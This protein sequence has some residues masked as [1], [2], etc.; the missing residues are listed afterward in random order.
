MAATER[1]GGLDDADA[2]ALRSLGIDLDQVVRHAEQAS[3][4]GALAQQ[5]GAPA[6]RQLMGVRV[7]AEIAPRGLRNRL[8]SGPFNLGFL[9]VTAIQDGARAARLL[10]EL[11]VQPDKVRSRLQAVSATGALPDRRQVG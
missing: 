3:R 2:E 7:E 9:A 5:R 6:G 8:R 10:T 1:R 4:P 11:G